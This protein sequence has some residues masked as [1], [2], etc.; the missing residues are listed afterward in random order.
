MTDR[1]R[2]GVTVEHNFETAHRLPALGGKCVNL[3][4]HSWTV[5]WEITGY[6][7]ADGILV[8]YG[9]LKRVLRSWVDAH[10]DHGTI[11]GAGDRLVHPLLEEGCRIFRFGVQKDD[12]T[13]NGWQHARPP[14]PDAEDLITDHPW[15]TVES[16]A[17]LLARAGTLLLPAAGGNETLEVRRVV[18]RETAVNGATWTV[19]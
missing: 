16:V 6:P 12:R 4:G 8:E 13:I 11:L 1:P 10:L 19:P 14:I 15:P 9:S 18:I 7:D 2:L 3:H 17:V 5:L